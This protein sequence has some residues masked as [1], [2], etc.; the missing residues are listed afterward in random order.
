MLDYALEKRQKKKDALKVVWI[1]GFLGI[2]FIIIITRF[3]LAGNNQFYSSAPTDDAVYAIAKRFVQPTL[4]NKHVSF[5]T[6]GY[7]FVKQRDSVYVIRSYAETKNIS[8][9]KE[10]TNFEIVLKYNGGSAYS[11]SNWEVLNLTE[12]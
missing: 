3:A 5:L 8:G 9:W 12:D 2:I 1:L 4:K 10:T 6:S 11:Q 7:K